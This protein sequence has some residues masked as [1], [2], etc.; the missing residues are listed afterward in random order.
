MKESSF[1]LRIT[2][3][4]KHRVAGDPGKGGPLRDHDSYSHRHQEKRILEKVQCQVHL[5][6]CQMGQCLDFC[7]A[8][9]YFPVS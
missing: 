5:P 7:I 4:G 9:L 2:S 1:R 3:S 6:S 8:S